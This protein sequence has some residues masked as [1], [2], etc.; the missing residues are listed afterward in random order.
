MI[1]CQNSIV[2]VNVRSVYHQLQALTQAFS[3]LIW[4]VFHSLADRSLWQ[5]APD[6]LK[7][8]LDFDN[9]FWLCFKLGVSLQ[10][11]SPHVIVHWVYIRQIWR[12]LVICYEIWTVGP[13]FVLCAARCVCWRAVLLEDESGGQLGKNN[14][15]VIN[16]INYCLSNYHCDVI[17]S[18]V[19]RSF[20]ILNSIF[21]LN[22]FNAE[23]SV[24]GHVKKSIAS[25]FFSRV[26]FYLAVRFKMFN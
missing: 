18:N 7:R 22:I 16:E 2:I 26:T 17:S 19:V 4:E 10:H 11:C 14:N 3:R 25:S 8:F 23:K 12:P 15:F 9:C 21:S 20:W 5:V 1:R 24:G 13:Q 6:D